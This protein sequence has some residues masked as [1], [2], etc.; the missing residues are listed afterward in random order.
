M[1]LVDV[2]IL[3]EMMSTRGIV[4]SGVDPRLSAARIARKI[5]L[6]PTTVRAR[7]R[8]WARS[9]FL[10]ALHVLPNPNVLGFSLYAGGLYVP[11]PR[12]RVRVRSQFALVDGAFQ[13]LEHVGGW[14]GVS[15]VGDQVTTMR[16]R[17]ELLARI[18]GVEEVQDF[19]D[20]SIPPS[21]RVPTPL[22]WRLLAALREDALAPV[23][24]VAAKL[25]VSSNTFHTRYS[26]LV[27]SR[28]IASLPSLDFTKFTGGAVT[29][30]IVSV[31]GPHVSEA[32]VIAMTRAFATPLSLQ[33]P[34]APDADGAHVLDLL[35]PLASA[36]QADDAL[37][38]VLAVPGVR[39]AEVL[40]PR[41]HHV[42]PRWMDERLAAAI[43]HEDPRA[44]TAR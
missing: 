9:G 25:G 7:I 2:G 37:S 24:A 42:Y 32:L 39:T 5:G 31:D 15:V 27:A 30:L 1:D 12:D 20:C 13:C 8:S 29:R 40:F 41:H 38:E 34:P 11:N 19:F 4:F 33:T 18:P 26:A 23:H 17:A 14:M 43:A 21:T 35:L 3:R 22:E 6:D 44:R 16:R 28:A 36:A 10:S